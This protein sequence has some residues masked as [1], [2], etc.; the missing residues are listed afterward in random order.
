MNRDAVPLSL[1]IVWEDPSPDWFRH[2]VNLTACQ[3]AKQEYRQIIMARRTIIFACVIRFKMEHK[4]TD[5][6]VNFPTNP[7]TKFE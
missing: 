5:M 2:W 1:G 6:I 7:D 4:H 3:P